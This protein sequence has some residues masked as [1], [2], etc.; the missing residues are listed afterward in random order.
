MTT[1]DL[2]NPLSSITCP[3]CL[4][5]ISENIIKT[6]CSHLYCKSCF[7]DFLDRGNFSCPMCRENIKSYNDGENL[8]RL[9]IKETN[10]IADRNIILSRVAEELL[11]ANRK[12]KCILWFGLLSFLC[13]REYIITLFTVAEQN[14]IECENNLNETISEYHICQNYND[15][16]FEKFNINH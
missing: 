10:D 13:Y 1:N 6:N 16:L 4:E 11:R 7:Y 3:I 9:I 5:N 8:W 2:E 15:Y 14:Y 12:M